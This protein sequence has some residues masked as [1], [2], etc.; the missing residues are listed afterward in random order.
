MKTFGNARGRKKHAG[1]RYLTLRDLPEKGIQYHVNHLRR[2][3]GDG[4]FPPPI[5]LSP[6]KVCWDERVIDAWIAAKIETV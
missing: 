3:W 2:M 6:R 1:K 5:Y 4:R